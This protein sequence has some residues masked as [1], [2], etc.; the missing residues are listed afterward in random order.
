MIQ[1]DRWNLLDLI[2][3]ID[4]WLFQ[5][6]NFLKMRWIIVLAVILTDSLMWM[7]VWFSHWCRKVIISWK[8]QIFLSHFYGH[9]IESTWAHYCDPPPTAI[10]LTDVQLF[11]FHSFSFLLWNISVVPNG[12]IQRHWGPC[13]ASTAFLPPP[14]S[15]TSTTPFFNPSV[16]AHFSFLNASFFL[17]F[18]STHLALLFLKLFTP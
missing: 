18:F 17:S 14:Y 10:Q 2:L 16:S 12:L 13:T 11:N 15:H 6:A 5:Q 1:W 3:Y 8:G 4:R 9:Y 7:S